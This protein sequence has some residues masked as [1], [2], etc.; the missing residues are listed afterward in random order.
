MRKQSQINVGDT[1]I[2]KVQSGE[3]VEG[4]VVHTWM[5]GSL[6]M[7]RVVSNSLVYN[8]PSTFVQRHGRKG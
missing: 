5:D 8:V 3:T 4:R 6:Q 1:V 2:I 7:V